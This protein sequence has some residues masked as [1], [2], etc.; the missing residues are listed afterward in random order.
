MRRIS[1]GSPI[2]NLAGAFE[3]W[4][5][6]ALKE[7]ENASYAPTPASL[8]SN[9]SMWPLGGSSLTDVLNRLGHA[10]TVTDDGFTTIDLSAY[11]NSA[12]KLDFVSSTTGGPN[13]SAWVR[14]DASNSG[15]SIGFAAGPTISVTTGAL[16]GTTGTDGRFTISA[17]ADGKVYLENRTGATLTFVVRQLGA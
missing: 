12:A 2:Q 17:G 1:L 9:D 6:T 10:Y 14:C 13:G 15:V 16:N 4:V 7:I 3:R 5:K 8:V 11:G